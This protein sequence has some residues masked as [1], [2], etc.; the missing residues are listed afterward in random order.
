MVETAEAVETQMMEQVVL[1]V[2]A[3]TVSTELELQ[4]MEMLNL[5]VEMVAMED[6]QQTVKVDNQVTKVMEQ[7]IEKFQELVMM[8]K[9]DKVER[10][11][12]VGNHLQI[13]HLNLK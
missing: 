9:M 6:H 12:I 2:T 8:E 4:L 13:I 7:V 11:Q 10:N 5:T 3:V 1:E